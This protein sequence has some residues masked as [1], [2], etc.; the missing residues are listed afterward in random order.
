MTI[1]YLPTFT[2]Q[3]STIHV[4]KYTVRPMDGMGTWATWQ[5]LLVTSISGIISGHDF[6]EGGIYEL[7]VFI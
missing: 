3:K 6:N 2:Y 1:V 4:G 5:G 7:F